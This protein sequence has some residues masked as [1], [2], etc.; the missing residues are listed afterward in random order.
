MNGEAAVS[1]TVWESEDVSYSQVVK[2]DGNGDVVWRTSLDPT[3]PGQ[4]EYPSIYIGNSGRVVAAIN[5][6][7]FNTNRV[8]NRVIKFDDQTGAI[9]SPLLFNGPASVTV[10]IF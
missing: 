4:S 5:N 1:L 2:L 10:Q 3:P 9:S 8:I 7:D 6:Y